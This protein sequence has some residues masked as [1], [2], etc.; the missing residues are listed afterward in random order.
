ML[1][2]ERKNN[3][4]GGQGTEDF[5]I[6]HLVNLPRWFLRRCVGGTLEEMNQARNPWAC[7]A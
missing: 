7:E 1:Q 5:S 2:E 6:R 4:K 3:E